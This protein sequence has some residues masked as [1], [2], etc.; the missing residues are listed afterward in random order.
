MEEKRFTITEDHEG[1]R[2]DV[3]LSS[4]MEGSRSYLHGLYQTAPRWRYTG[5][6]YT[7]LMCKRSYSSQRQCRLYHWSLSTHLRLTNAYFIY[8]I[9]LFHSDLY[10]LLMRGGNIFS[11]VIGPNR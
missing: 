1:Q 3:F 6:E 10:L 9:P 2:L 5:Y 8:F 11:Y 7:K 4:H